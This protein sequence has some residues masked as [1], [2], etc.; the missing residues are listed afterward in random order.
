MAGSIDK[1]EKAMVLNRL[2]DFL[3][4]NDFD[5]SIIFGCVIDDK[6]TALY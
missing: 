3:K 6:I 4:R 2:I 1:S 5:I